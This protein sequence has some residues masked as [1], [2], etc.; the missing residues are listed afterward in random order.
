L[1]P[2]AG[3]LEALGSIHPSVLG[4]RLVNDR[5]WLWRYVNVPLGLATLAALGTHAIWPAGGFWINLATTFIGSIVAVNYI[6]RV[7]ERRTRLEWRGAVELIGKRLQYVAFG[8][9]TNVRGAIGLSANQLSIS[10]MDLSDRAAYLNLCESEIEPAVDGLVRTLDQNQWKALANVL[11]IAYRDC[12]DLLAVFGQKIRPTEFRELIA[13]QDDIRG[14]L[15]MHSTF[16]DVLGVPDEQLTPNKRRD[17]V[18]FKHEMTRQLAAQ[19]ST[20]VRKFRQL[21]LA[22]IEFEDHAA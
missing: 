19:V 12:Q 15:G 14:V 8:T 10:R 1:N 7:V 18:Q 6:D 3:Q 5:R 11:Q 16:P 20:I 9:I 13:L 17:H 4:K 21:G 22:A 2:L